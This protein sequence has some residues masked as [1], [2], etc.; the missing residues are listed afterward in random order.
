MAVALF[1]VTLV[2]CASI[3]RQELNSLGSTIEPAAVNFAELSNYGRHARA[4]YSSEE[5]IRAAYPRTIRV[6]DVGTTGVRY[7]LEQDAKEKVHFLSI[8]GTANHKN[9][10]EDMDYRVREDRRSKIPV[11]SGF[12]EDAQAVYADV[13]PYLKTGYRTHLSGHSLGGAVASLVALY[14]IEDGYTVDRV[15][16]FGQPRFTTAKGAD[17]IGFLPLL[18]VVDENDVIPLLPPSVVN[19]TYGPY[20]QVGPEVILLEGPRYVYLASHDA[21]RISVGE[22]WR[23]IGIADL[24]DHH[25][26]NYLLRLSEKVKG[27]VEVAYN[28]R[29]K[30]TAR[31]PKKAAAVN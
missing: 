10:H 27:A 26:D 4:A 25:M 14:A 1:A 18:R 3:S 5:Q 12:D 21:S 6:A 15:I 8:R 13:K 31:P 11:H 9:L 23:N 17:Q 16:T 30:Y 28:D 24:Q 22:F 20:E 29:E 2:G 19:K 7:F